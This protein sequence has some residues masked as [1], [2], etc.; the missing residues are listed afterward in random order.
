MIAS[1]D[2]PSYHTI[3]IGAGAAGL[4]AATRAAELGQRTVLIEKNRKVGVKILI[5]GGTRCNVTHHTDL[6]GI[7][8]GFGPHGKFLRHA[9]QE[10]GPTDVVKMLAD[11][12]VE[13]KVETNGK[14]FPVSDKAFDVQ[15][16]L[17]RRLNASG[18]E[19]ANQQSVTNIQ[20]L[21]NGFLVSTDTQTFSG[22]RIILTTGGLSYP[23]CGT[24]GD[25]YPWLRNL[26]HTV[27]PTFPALV[28]VRTSADWVPTIKGLS[29]TDAQ[30]SVV[31]R[32]H[33]E[34]ASDP[35]SRF[36]AVKK[37]ALLQRRAPLL[38]TH[39]GLS[40]PAPM[41]VSKAISSHAEPNSLCCVIDLLPGPEIGQTW[42]HLQD[43]ILRNGNWSIGRI[44]AQQL[45]SQQEV[46]ERLV[47]TILALSDINKSQKAA[48]VNKKQRQ[49]L[50]QSLRSLAIPVCDTLGYA[51]AEVT[52]G[53]V[54][55]KEIDAHSMQSKICPG[56]F[57]AGEILDLDGR[58][59][60]FNFQAAFSTGWLAGSA[61]IPSH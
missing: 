17:L 41:D 34:N 10:F 1:P 12:G 59:G 36:A 24:T 2:L 16:A 21:E 6:A 52:T 53:G 51:K 13:T 3:V 33:L 27:T 49:C 47:E 7:M 15:Q 22:Q 19:L 31:R 32:G 11:Q 57:V 14:I 43:A 45:L 42:N 56:L 50:L 40:G 23:G 60:G 8:Q 54:S 38:F 20:R 18:C 26:G 58:I 39:F 29:L 61:A 4:L 30:I 5:S 28:P 25:G 44:V 35:E 9:L 48:E 55:L 46:P 37:R